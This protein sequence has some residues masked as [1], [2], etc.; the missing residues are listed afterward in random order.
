MVEPKTPQSGLQAGVAFW[1]HKLEDDID[2]ICW[3]R[4]HEIGIIEQEINN[5]SAD[6]GVGKVNTIE[7]IGNGSQGPD[8]RERRG[9]LFGP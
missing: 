6:E 4:G 1:C 8:I 9:D 7:P 2:I 5:G 3:P